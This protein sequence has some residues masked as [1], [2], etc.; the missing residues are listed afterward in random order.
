MKKTILCVFIIFLCLTASVFADDTKDMYNAIITGDLAKAKTLLDGGFDPNTFLSDGQPAVMEAAQTGNIAMVELFIKSGADVTLMA[1]NNFGGNALTGAVWSTRDTHD[2][3]NTNKIIQMLLDAGIDINSGEVRNESDD[4]EVG[5]K[6]YESY[7]NPIWFVTG[8]TD[9][10]A[11]VLEF[12]ISKGNNLSWAY[13]VSEANDERRD[14]SL[15]ETI[16]AVKKSKSNKKDKKEYNRIMKILKDA[17]QKPAPKVAAAPAPV[18][19]PAPAPEP[20]PA[21]KEAAKAPAQQPEAKKAPAQK[22]AEKHAPVKEVK[23]PKAV[24]APKTKPQKP[25]SKPAPAEAPKTYSSVIM[26]PTE[27]TDMLRKAVEEGNKENFYRSLVMGADVNNVDNENKSVLLLAVMSN[28][29]EMVEVLIHKGA[30]VNVKSKG[31]NTPLSMAR[32][33]GST[34][35]EQLLLTAG[36]KN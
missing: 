33:L 8:G 11:D 9:C 14:A 4:Y 6:L 27:A 17:E 26:S 34:D 10:N 25:V 19:A 31:G 15:D 3:A 36:A 7:I 12:M 29:T 32:D 23:T 35:I 13:V 1:D 21:V 24:K 16:D 18:P 2:P 20:Q 28:K 5:G 30:D 22:P